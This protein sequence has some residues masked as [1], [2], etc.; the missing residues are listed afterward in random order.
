M[1]LTPFQKEVA[2]V[3]AVN[4]NP[5]SHLAGGAVINREDGSPR[6]SNDL[7][8]FHDAS[9]SV[10]LSA[11]ADFRALTE[12]G[13]SVDWEIRQPGFYRAILRRDANSLKLEWAQDSAFRFFPVQPDDIFGFRLHQADL[14]TNK[15]LALVGRSEVRD[16][17]E[18]LYLDEC[19]LSLGAIVWAACGKDEGFTPWSLLDMAKRHVRY[20]EEDLANE[21]LAQSLS[22]KDLKESWIAA[23]ARAEELFAQLPLEEVGC[24]YL[25]CQNVPVTPIPGNPDTAK[26]IR[27]FGSLRGAW[28]RIK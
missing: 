12:A 6:Y 22:L 28:P 15:A 19:C 18:I 17:I 5:D 25:D 20:R 16:F 4:R 13:Y 24:L 26:L 11:E 1:P 27:H 2:R 10:A 23:A 14:A 3:L 7:D 9:E 8:L 21:N